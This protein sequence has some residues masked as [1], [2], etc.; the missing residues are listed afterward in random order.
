MD[1]LNQ[2]LPESQ[3]QRTLVYI[4]IGAFVF[5]FLVMPMLSKE[6]FVETAENV[7]SLPKIDTNVCSR[8]CC[9]HTQWPV[10]HAPVNKEM[11]AK[12]IGSN[13]MCNNGGSG[14]TQGG[15]VCFS[16]SDFNYLANRGTNA[17]DPEKC[18]K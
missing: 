9:L 11:A 14:N 13:M 18:L 5:F 16:K 4:I 10:A 6:T 3:E 15:C 1:F 17:G 8:D 2:I 7:S 12:Y